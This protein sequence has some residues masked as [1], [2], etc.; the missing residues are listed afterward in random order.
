MENAY[1]VSLTV[2]DL[3]GETPTDAAKVFQSSMAD[4]M[5]LDLTFG[6]NDGETTHH[7]RLSGIVPADD[8]P[9]REFVN[10]IQS[11]RNRLAATGDYVDTI[12]AAHAMLGNLIGEQNQ[13]QP[14]EHWGNDPAYP[15]DDWRAEVANDETRLGYAEWLAVK[16]EG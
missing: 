9:D 1:E 14:F 3:F 12:R 5:S 10:R 8:K 15:V 6:V 16:R 7:V 11:V 2:P 4:W 13:V